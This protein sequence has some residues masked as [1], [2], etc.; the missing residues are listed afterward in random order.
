[1]TAATRDR[2]YT[3]RVS[4]KLRAETAVAAEEAAAEAG[5]K[6]GEWVRNAICEALVRK[7]NNRTVLAEVV[8]M[9]A[10]FLTV[11]R[12]I[13]GGGK[14]SEEFL[15]Q[16]VEEADARKF[17]LADKRIHEAVSQ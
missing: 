1:M 13:V 17:A 4:A 6:L 10:I 2:V 15:L 14:L 5:V 11:G 12:E 3:A 7:A 9:R 8:A 16:V